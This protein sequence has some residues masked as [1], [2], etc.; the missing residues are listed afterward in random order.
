M[1]V[2]SHQFASR[3][4]GHCGVDQVRQ[5]RI[6]QF[7]D[8]SNGQETINRK[9]IMRAEDAIRGQSKRGLA[10][11]DQAVSNFKVSI[12]EIKFL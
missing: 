1:A 3:C 11:S 9:N 5:M 4:R 7:V 12:D 2:G 6:V 10:I 8:T